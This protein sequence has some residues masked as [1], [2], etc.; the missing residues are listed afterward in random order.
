MVHTSIK[1]N[2]R[3]Q[4]SVEL[5]V[6]LPEIGK[7]A[8]I[9]R[10]VSS[11]KK[12]KIVPADDDVK[13]VLAEV[14]EHPEIMLSRRE[15]L[16]FIL[17]EPTKRS[18]E[19]QTILKLDEI[20]QTRSSLNTAQNKLQTAQRNAAA[21]A[22]SGRDALQLHLQIPT[23]RPEDLLEAVNKR[24]KMLVLPEI[25]QL[26][27]DTKLDAGLAAAAKMPDFNKQSALRDLKAL[28]DAANKF[29]DLAKT[30]AA[31]ILSDL[32]KLGADPAL[33]AALQRRSFIEKGLD[34]M[35]GPE[36]PLCDHSWGDAQHLRKHL[37][38]KLM[39]SEEA[40]KL[41]ETL[42]KNGGAL[43]KEAIGVVG[44]VGLVQKIAE[45]QGEG[46]FAQ[47][48]AAFIFLL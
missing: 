33:L 20:G 10:K 3:T 39:K 6:F 35:D 11:P 9:T 14:A 41:Q 48:L 40:R 45:T 13:A 7:S 38:V 44:L 4:H 8:T 28:S 47:I 46:A 27:A 22:E 12:P 23:Q 36:C 5:K 18:E 29:P 34:L 16:R 21:Q 43:V 1:R 15:I 42:V 30:E 37:K 2:S 32:A 26:T 31:A 24:R 25:A 19:I 17:V